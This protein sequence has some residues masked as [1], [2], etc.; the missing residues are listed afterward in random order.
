[1][2]GLLLLIP[3]SC[4]IIPGQESSDSTHDTT[5]DYIEP[6]KDI[7]NKNWVI[8]KKVTA[9]DEEFASMLF[10][11]DG[12]WTPTNEDIQLIE[13]GIADFLIQNSSEFYWQPPVWQRLDEYNRQYIGLE[14]GG[15][16]FIFGNYFCE[17]GSDNWRKEIMFAIDGGECYF[18]VE[19]NLEN[20]SFI[21]LH[22]NGES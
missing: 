8:L 4:I 14:R 15:E 20:G 5:L 3:L 11:T 7:K 22:V 17:S 16:K 1:M 19:F 21:R 13:E 6:T 18:Q 10:E 9:K 2:A 12:F